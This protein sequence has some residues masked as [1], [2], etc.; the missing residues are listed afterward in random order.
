M[1]LALLWS[2]RKR[3]ANSGRSA[4]WLEVPGRNN[5]LL[6]LSRSEM[7]VNDNFYFF[8]IVR[9]ILAKDVFVFPQFDVNGCRHAA[10][11]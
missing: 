7:D 10:P 8:R 3:K 5:S 6:I 1:G 11:V 9:K 4:E 2:E